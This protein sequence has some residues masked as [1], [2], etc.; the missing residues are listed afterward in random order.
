MCSDVNRLSSVFRVKS[1][2]ALKSIPDTLASQ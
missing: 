1:V 2:H